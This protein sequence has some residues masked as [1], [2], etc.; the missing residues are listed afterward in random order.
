MSSCLYWYM[1][2]VGSFFIP[3]LMKASNHTL[4]QEKNGTTLY[5]FCACAI[6]YCNQS[7]L[8]NWKDWVLYSLV[9]LALFY[10]LEFDHCMK[11]E[12]AVK[13][14]QIQSWHPLLDTHAQAHKRTNPIPQHRKPRTNANNHIA[15]V[16]DVMHLL[17]IISC[18]FLFN[19]ANISLLVLV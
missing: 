6:A 2:L 14:K 7:N 4:Q 19:S 16:Y 12:Q 8:F 5:F 15:C 1:L 9:L 11:L 3:H 17:M 13:K 10:I 18:C